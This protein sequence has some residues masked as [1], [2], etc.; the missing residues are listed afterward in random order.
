MDVITLSR[1]EARSVYDRIGARQ[2]TQA[3]YE[4][5]ATEFLISHGEFDRANRVF[6]LGCGTGRFALRLLS[7]HLPENARYLGVDLS[8][9]MANLARQRLAPYSSRAQVI[10]TDGSLPTVETLGRCDRFVSNYVLDLLSEDDIA[11]VIR[12]AHRMLEPSGLLCLSSLSMGSGPLSGLVARAWSFVHAVRPSL[13]G[14]CRPLDLLAWLPS[15]RWQ[16]RHH[17]RVAPFSVPSEVV[18][19]Q[20]R[21]ASSV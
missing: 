21:N 4:D 10:L 2:D 20:P 5:R 14:G 19:A 3:F 16:V 9:T 8:S 17:A 7:E 13:V 11:T 18:I 15:A 12:E 1:Q 6:E